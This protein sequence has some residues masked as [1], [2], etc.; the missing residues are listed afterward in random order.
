MV[1]VGEIERLTTLRGPQGLQSEGMPCIDS[2]SSSTTLCHGLI[3]F[4]ALSLDFPDRLMNQLIDRMYLLKISPVSYN[5]FWSNT[6][7]CG[8]SFCTCAYPTLPQWK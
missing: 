2:F 5:C 6:F 7:T 8:G 4:S 1:C 3:S